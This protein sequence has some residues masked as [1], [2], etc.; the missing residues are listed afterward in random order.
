MSTE[1][2]PF[3]ICSLDEVEAEPGNKEGRRFVERFI[4]DV[5]ILQDIMNK[6]IAGRL[7]ELEKW[8]GPSPRVYKNSLA[9]ESMV[10]WLL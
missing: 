10:Q 2:G 4:D 8:V 1:T 5:N 6:S 3:S 9:D 7:G